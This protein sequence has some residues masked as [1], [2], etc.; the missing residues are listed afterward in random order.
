[1]NYKV[2]IAALLLATVARAQTLEPPPIGWAAMPMNGPNQLPDSCE[3]GVDGDLARAGQPNM[4]IRCQDQV[5]AFGGL[6]QAFE[7]AP[8]LGKRVRFSGWIQV[9]GV[10]DAGDVAAGAGLWINV[11]TSERRPFMDR[12]EDRALSGYSSWEYR[13]FVVDIEPDAGPFINIGFWL[14]GSGQMW[15]RDLNFEVVS[16]AVPVNLEV[17]WED[18]LRPNLTLE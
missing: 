5:P 18:V 15:V 2:L 12:M 4:S 1:M 11:P 6:R 17:D 14:E 8:Y 16:D 9:E 3:M 10:E 13:D 7:S